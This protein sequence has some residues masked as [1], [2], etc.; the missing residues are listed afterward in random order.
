MVHVFTSLN[1][2]FCTRL[3]AICL[4]PLPERT[5]NELSPFARMTRLLWSF[6]FLHRKKERKRK[7]LFNDAHNTFYLRSY[8][9]RP[10]RYKERKPPAAS[11]RLAARVILYASSHR[12]D[13]TYHGLCYTSRGAL[14]GT[15]N[16]SMGPP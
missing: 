13:N 12:Q 16:T 6:L 8:G 11:F 2:S 15:R 1:A 9:I 10:F 14:P 4:E 5:F 7:C 3:A